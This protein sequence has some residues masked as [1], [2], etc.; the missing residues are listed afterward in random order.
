MTYSTW[1]IIFIISL[2]AAVIFSVTAAVFAVKF[3]VISLIRFNRNEKKNSAGKNA[4]AD[5]CPETKKKTSSV[6]EKLT[7]KTE[8]MQSATNPIGTV[9]AGMCSDP[10]GT[11]I[12]GGSIRPVKNIIVIHSDPSVI[13]ELLRSEE[14]M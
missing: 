6:T 11:V 5:L 14:Q 1:N 13:D 10:S 8:K 9:I 7:K 2:T 12:A 4:A 3:K